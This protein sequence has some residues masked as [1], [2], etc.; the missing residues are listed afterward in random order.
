MSADRM[1]AGRYRLVRLIGRG[2]FGE[3]W[4]SEDTVL[5]RPVAIKI[6]AVQTGD[7]EKLRRFGREARTLARLNHTNVVAV[8]DS[9]RDDGTAYVVMAL[10]AGP[11]LAELL[12]ERGALPLAEAVGY[13]AQA[14]AGLSAAHAAGIVHRD[15]SPANLMLDG[16][17]TLK[18]VD[19]GVARLTLATEGLTA[20]GTVFATAGYVSPEQAAGLPATTQSDLYALG[21]VLYALLAGEPP[22]V[23]E[24][25]LGVINQHLTSPPPSLAARRPEVPHDLDEL[26]S[27][28]LAKE[29]AGRPADAGEVQQ[30]L[31]AVL[32][33]LDGSAGPTLRLAAARTVP[34]ATAATRVIRRRRTPRLRLV[35]GLALALALLALGVLAAVVS[36]SRGKTTGTTL[37]HSNT[38]TTTPVSTQATTQA[39]T[40]LTSTAQQTPTTPAQALADARAALDQAQAG[41]QLDPGTA[42]DL[43]H[44]L[45]DLAKALE[46]NPN[47][48]AK[49]LA[50]L[51]KRLGDLV[52]G[53]QLSGAGV[54]GITTPLDELAALLPAASG[55]GD[56]KKHKG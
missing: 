6:L 15:V 50:D 1:L 27:S 28:L 41:G 9:G 23:G 52:N 7:E 32:N 33:G 40:A 4:E 47:D 42:G 34:F 49:K 35:V 45:D 48:A 24:H 38:S 5:G 22:F 54:A 16:D 51:R 3:V 37:A 2:G 26:V 46:K 10:L 13:A 44:R 8:Y 21:C 55:P 14:A 17:G 53:G 56:G 18:V 30:R 36:T 43:G 19:F 11:S 20:T 39:T 31:V 12:V 25:P 29:P